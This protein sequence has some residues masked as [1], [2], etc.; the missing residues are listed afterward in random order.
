MTYRLYCC[1][2]GKRNPKNEENSHWDVYLQDRWLHEQT[3]RV[4]KI[5]Q[6]ADYIRMREYNLKNAKS[7][8]GGNI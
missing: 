7:S 5:K 1:K 2:C 6:E 8:L 4:V 3:T